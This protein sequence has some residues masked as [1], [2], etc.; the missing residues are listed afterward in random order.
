[1]AILDQRGRLKGCG[2][3]NAASAVLSI[4]QSLTARPLRNVWR[5]QVEVRG[6][7]YWRNDQMSDS[8]RRKWN[9]GA[10]SVRETGILMMVF[11]PLEGALRDPAVTLS[12]MA[13]AFGIG[14]GLILLGI[15]LQRED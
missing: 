12:T 15:L 11:G 6:D 9:L 13:L 7:H 14:A 10:E 2:I 5:D 3:G 4:T 8:A 1:M